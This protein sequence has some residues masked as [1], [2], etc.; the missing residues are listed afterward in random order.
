M[1]LTAKV[2]A[3]SHGKSRPKLRH[4]GQWQLRKVMRCPKSELWKVM[5]SYGLAPVAKAD[6][7]RK[8]AQRSRL[9]HC[10]GACKALQSQKQTG[11]LA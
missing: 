8:A 6:D 7:Y 10:S 4:A 1:D 3:A 5:E 2:W 9:H 11:A